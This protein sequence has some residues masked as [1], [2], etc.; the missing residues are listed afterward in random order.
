MT[1]DEPLRELL[2]HLLEWEA[3]HVGFD[4][5]VAYCRPALR[6]K[7][8]AGLPHSPWELL[9]HI[10][11]AQRD[12]LDFCTDPDY[13]EKEWPKDFWPP[14]P[15]PPSDAAWDASIEAFRKDRERL[16]ALARDGDLTAPI[17]HGDGA[18]LLVELVLAA[19]HAAYHVGQLVLVRRALGDWTS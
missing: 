10:R 13:R 4:K 7:R 3:A 12:I 5:A 19:D 11:R 6:G 8:P 14:A 9:E 18:T 2:G 15:A 16:A 1:H 17:P